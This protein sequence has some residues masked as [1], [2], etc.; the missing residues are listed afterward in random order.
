MYTTSLQRHQ[1]TLN[2]LTSPCNITICPIILVGGRVH[3]RR[4]I[5]KRIEEKTYPLP[6]ASDVTSYLKYFRQVL[7]RYNY[8][9]DSYMYY[10]KSECT[11]LQLL[12]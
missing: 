1:V 5:Y 10:I 11:L 2:I 9:H 8:N 12:L 6:S 3:G 7:L 4:Q